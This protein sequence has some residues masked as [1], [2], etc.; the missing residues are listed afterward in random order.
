M[1][2]REILQE[3][4][5]E[6]RTAGEHH[7]ARAEWVQVD[8]PFCSPNSQHFRMGLKGH[9]ANCWSCGPY[10]I[11]FALCELTGEP[12]SRI[13]VWLN[14]WEDHTETPEESKPKGKLTLPKGTGLLQPCHIKYLRS[15]G[16]H[17]GE[18]VNLWGLQGIGLASRL[19]WRILIPIHYRGEV[20]SW[21]TRAIIDVP[22]KYINARPEE[23]K[24]SAKSLIYGEDYCRHAIIVVEGP[25]SVW[26][27]GP[28]AGATL[29]TS[30][31]DAQV[32]K[33]SRYPSRAVVFDNEPLAQARAKK[34][35]DALAPFPGKT[36][37]V[38]I[39][40]GKDPAEASE[41]EITLLRKTFLE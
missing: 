12:Y 15:R 37:R 19:A 31:S 10:K 9:T 28:G 7:H 13:K 14:D 26:R 32:L 27:I 22:A 18:L 2:L 23:E 17:I 21:T 29:G 34:L 35:C 3:H 6:F 36:A 25:T 33:I 11:S 24:L 8:C 38:E 5:I 41:D 30:F 39:T 40:S 16:F 4:G 20:V 1:N